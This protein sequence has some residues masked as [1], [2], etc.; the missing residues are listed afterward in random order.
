[1]TKKTNHNCTQALFNK[2]RK[3]KK[4]CGR[5]SQ[6]VGKMARTNSYSKKKKESEVSLD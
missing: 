2:K 3:A 5:K 6:K 1:M 4:L